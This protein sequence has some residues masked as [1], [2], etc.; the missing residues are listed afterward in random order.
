M[1]LILPKLTWNNNHYQL[2]I[3]PA[4]SKV[5]MQVTQLDGLRLYKVNLERI[6]N[7]EFVNNN[8]ADPVC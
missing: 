3:T 7:A 2:P 1:S 6:N 4:L 5:R 8:N